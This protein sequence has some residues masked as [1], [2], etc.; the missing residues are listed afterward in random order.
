MSE[1]GRTSNRSA[2]T[3]PRWLWIGVCA[4]LALFAVNSTTRLRFFSPDSMNYVDVARHIAAGRG[5]VQSTLGFNQPHFNPAAAIPAPTTMQPPLYP[6][7]IGALIRMGVEPGSAALAIPAVCYGLILVLGW[8]IAR[9]MGG[10]AAGWLA[11]AA[12]LPYFPLTFVSRFAFSEPLA[13]ALAAAAWIAAGPRPPAGSRPWVKD[14]L[15][16]VLAGLSVATRFAFLPI[17]AAIAVR[18]IACRTSPRDR[19]RAVVLFALGAFG[20]I[21]PILARNLGIEGMLMPRPNPPLLGWRQH[22]ADGAL[23]LLAQYAGLVRPGLQ[24][25][26]LAVSLALIGAAAFSG[27]RAAPAS[28]PAFRRDAAALALWPLFYLGF[29]L[30]QRSRQ[31]FDPI[32]VRLIAPAG[33]ALIVLGAAW[34]GRRFTGGVRIAAALAA[35]SLVGV[36]GREVALGRTW[37]VYDA[38]RLVATSPTLTWIARN[39]DDRDLVIGNNTM[40]LAFYLGRS[41]AVSFSPYP[42]TDHAD[43]DRLVEFCRRNRTRYRGFYVVL[44]GRAED[45]GWR[46]FYGNLFADLAAGK[47]SSYPGVTP[48]AD[49]PDGVIYRL[50][51]PGSQK[52]EG[53]VQ[54]SE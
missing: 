22:A 15:A 36:I 46:F 39:T 40:D 17:G 29:L 3:G 53:R 24:A 2:T 27:R 21:A 20:C 34:V 4:Y 9:A 13:I 12:L 14:L 23:S 32:D 44:R 48:A 49:L 42:Y 28:D 38:E 19:A 30:W 8:R 33:V 26:I 5:I 51:P 1:P 18:L 50:T 31:H 16:G 47:T 11:L 10:T 7:A 41:A 43:W 6:A 37:P 45:A 52:A 54:R 35:A 25:G